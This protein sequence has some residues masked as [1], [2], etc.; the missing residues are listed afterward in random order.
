MVLSCR[1]AD[2][3]EAIW[4]TLISTG[5][6]YEAG[7]DISRLPRYGMVLSYRAADLRV[8]FWGRKLSG[9]HSSVREYH[10]RLGQISHGY[11]GTVWY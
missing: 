10:T 9:G 11:Q 2:L 6:S 3:K 7:T 8:F 4:R 1:A 5:I